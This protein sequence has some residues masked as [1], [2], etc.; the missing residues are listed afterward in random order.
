MLR[1]LVGSHPTRCIRSGPVAIS[2]VAHA[3]VIGAALMTTRGTDSQ[4]HGWND[5]RQE[6]PP[7][8]QVRYLIPTPTEEGEV[9]R[10]EGNVPDGPARRAWM[11]PLGGRHEEARTQLATLKATFDA[12]THS[13]DIHPAFDIADVMRGLEADFAPSTSEADSEF[14]NGAARMSDLAQLVPSAKN[15]IY[16]PDLVD[17]TVTPRPGNPKPQYPASLLAAGVEADVSVRFVVDSTGRVKEPSIEFRTHVHQLF[18]EA[19]RASLRRS[20]FFP[21]RFATMVVP[22]LVQQEFRFELRDRR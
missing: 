21:A 5:V 17:E 15:G 7:L 4:A 20:R 12:V 22:Q 10:P 19:I 6:T 18:M 14:N 16:T 3:V 2:A 11:N 9:G 13:L 8:V 1:E